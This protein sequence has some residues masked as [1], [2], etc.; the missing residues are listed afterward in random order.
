M[1]ASLHNEGLSGGPPKFFTFVETPSGAL[2]VGSCVRGISRSTDGGASWTPVGGLD[3]V[4]VNTLVVAD[5]GALLAATSVG[6]WRSDDDAAT[7]TRVDENAGFT[8]LPDGTRGPVGLTTFRLLELRD[9][10]TIAGTDGRGVWVDD[11]TTWHHLGAAETIVYSLAETAAGSI[12][13]G[14]RGGGILRSDDGGASWTPSN[15]GLPDVYVH[16]I[17]ELQDGS[18]LAGTGHGVSRSTDDGQTWSAYASDFDGHRVF[19]L[20]ELRDGQIAAGS[21]A[22]LWI[23]HDESWRSVDPGLTPDETWSVLF[24]DDGNLFAGAKTGLMR[25]VD[26]G[27]HWENVVPDSVVLGLTLTDD[28]RVLTVGDAGV[29]T[30]PDWS[31]LGELGPRAMTLL[32][33]E[34]GTVLAGTLSDGM[35]RYRDGTWASLPEGPPHWQVYSIIRSRSGRLLASTGAILDGL[36]LGG[37]FTCDDGGETWVETLSGRS[38]YA[39]SQSSDGT[40]YAGGRRC[41]ISRSTDDGDSWEELP[42]PLGQEAK[43]Y[44]LFVDSADRIYIGSGG[45][46]L[47]SDDAAATWTLLDDGIDGISVYDVRERDGLLAAATTAGVFV[48]T[49]AGNT[50]RAGELVS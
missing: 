23:G 41:Y 5:D 44:S 38:Y 28:G 49:D 31:P 33:T 20:L 42:L 43:M 9:G 4:S 21:Y 47:R 45:Q 1:A 32:E 40:I 19:A 7:W 10:R 8:V 50:W 30:G 3:H 37:V 17:V 48:S 18:I 15:D 39:L 16:C 36:K 12:L 14:T 22:H 27:A 13:A 35:Y 29:R 46:L 25:S 2:L 6:L 26:H 24:D 34:P 11:G